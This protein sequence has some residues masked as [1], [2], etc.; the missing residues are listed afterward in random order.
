MTIDMER[1]S[2]NLQSVAKVTAILEG[3]CH[4]SPLITHVH[5]RLH[6]NTEYNG[7]A[8][9]QWLAFQRA[10]LAIAL[11]L[12]HHWLIS[13]SW[14]TGF[15]RIFSENT[16]KKKRNLCCSMVT[17]QYLVLDERA[18]LQRSP[19]RYFQCT[20]KNH[21]TQYYCSLLLAE[22]DSQNK[23][24]LRRPE[25]CFLQIYTICTT[26]SY[27]RFLRVTT[28]KSTLVSNFNPCSTRRARPF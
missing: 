22:Y 20:Q 14:Q 2:A 1:A 7:K 13:A 27:H 25:C 18:Y 16:R 10:Q 15:T 5:H 26:V 3:N 4:V 19:P 24:N 9:G 12:A 6:L 11:E 23:I 8:Q 17:W 21:D 28:A